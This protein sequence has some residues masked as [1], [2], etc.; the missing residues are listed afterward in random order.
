MATVDP[1]LSTL[2]AKNQMAFQER[3]S[4]TAHQR[5]VADL[6]AAGLNP[7]LSAGGSGASTPSGAEG[8]Y[9]GSQIG[10][11]ISSS[12]NTTAKA[13]GAMRDTVESVVDSAKTETIFRQLLPIINAYTDTGTGTPS[14]AK[15]NIFGIYDP[16]IPQQNLINDWVEKNG[17]GKTKFKWNDNKGLFQNLVAGLNHAIFNGVVDPIRYQLSGQGV[18]DLPKIRAYNQSHYQPTKFEKK[19]QSALSNFKTNWRNSVKASFGK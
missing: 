11:L 8:D 3:M 13:L 1:R 19:V 18:K 10:Q 4:N 2:S 17:S 15:T 6:K 7:V 5:E 9:S 16:T 12:F 14:S